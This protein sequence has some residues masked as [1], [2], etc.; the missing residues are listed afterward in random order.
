MNDPQPH[1]TTI[2]PFKI[3]MV[4]PLPM[5]SQS[6]RERILEKA[7]HNLFLVAAKHVT[8]DFLTDSGTSAMSAAQWGAMM[9]ADESYAGSQSFERFE[10]VVQ[11]L[12]GYRMSSRLTRGGRLNA[13]S[14]AHW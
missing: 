6:E 14:L 7:G 9:T 3:K 5:L 8:F 2:E 12:T 4:E 11:N 10:K 13:S 1:R